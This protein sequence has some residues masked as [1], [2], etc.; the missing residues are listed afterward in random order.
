MTGLSTQTWAVLSRSKTHASITPFN[1]VQQV[2]ADRGGVSCLP[3]FRNN[4][5]PGNLSDARSENG[6]GRFHF[7]AE[8]RLRVCATSFPSV[9]L[10]RSNQRRTYLSRGNVKSSR[11]VPGVSHLSRYFPDDFASRQVPKTEGTSDVT[12]EELLWYAKSNK[13][14]Q[15]VRI[16]PYNWL[17]LIL[18]SHR[19]RM[20][21]KRWWCSLNYVIVL[22]S[23]AYI[24]VF[25]ILYYFIAFVVRSKA[26]YTESTPILLSLDTRFFFLFFISVLKTQFYDVFNSRRT[27][28]N[29]YIMAQQ[30]EIIARTVW[31]YSSNT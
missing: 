7:G 22:F 1:W 12:V 20:R 25:F 10:A 5:F 23:Y 30:I 11:L 21:L 15:G 13:H 4:K 17:T 27:M 9:S 8:A 16:N 3:L 6:S 24:C 29:Y 19:S 2:A 31:V 26:P 18:Y 28:M 14:V